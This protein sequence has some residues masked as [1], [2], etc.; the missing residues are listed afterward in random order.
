MLVLTTVFGEMVEQT[1][2]M[3]LRLTLGSEFL[4]VQHI[5]SLAAGR[6]FP[7]LNFFVN[8]SENAKA[9]RTTSS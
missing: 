9:G 6:I 2:L 1:V 5:S 4:F 7:R 8:I 3:F